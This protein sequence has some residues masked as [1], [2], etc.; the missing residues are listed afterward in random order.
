MYIPMYGRHG[1]SQ[2]IKGGVVS[3]FIQNPQ[4]WGCAIGKQG[5]VV[6]VGLNAYGNHRQGTRRKRLQK[7]RVQALN[8]RTDHTLMNINNKGWEGHTWV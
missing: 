6:N 1:V 2:D 7:V 4:R 5:Y 3:C 8:N